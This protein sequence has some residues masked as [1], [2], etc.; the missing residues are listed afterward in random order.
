MPEP[1]LRFAR[2]IASGELP[3]LLEGTLSVPTEEVGHVADLKEI[4]N[5]IR[6][7]DSASG[8]RKTDYDIVLSELLHQALRHLPVPVRLDMR[9]WHWMAISR[10]PGFVWNR[11][12]SGKPADIATALVQEAKKQRFLGTRSLRGR[13]R[14]AFSRLFFTAEILHDSVE[15]YKLAATAFAN[16]DRHTSIFERE[17]GL[18]P[19]AAKALV[20][21]TAR[22]DSKGIQRTAKRLNHI[23]SSLV[24]ETVPQSDLIKLLK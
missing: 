15:G 13:N 11:W 5:A 8:T 2:S 14:N 1:V 9:M 3:G 16:Q 24:I 4:D 18:V 22:M 10:F 6:R 17:L 19:D 7:L 23:A 21:L 20:R 12:F